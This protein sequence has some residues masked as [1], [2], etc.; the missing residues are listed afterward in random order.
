M[1][2][3]EAFLGCLS[4]LS[5]KC[6]WVTELAPHRHGSAKSNHSLSRQ[7]KIL[8]LSTLELRPRASISVW[9]AYHKEKILNLGVLCPVHKVTERANFGKRGEGEREK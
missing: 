5:G 3:V 7:E 8:F 6:L 4:S 2:V 9:L 1:V